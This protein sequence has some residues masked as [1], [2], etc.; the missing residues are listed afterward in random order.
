MPVPTSHS[1]HPPF[2]LDTYL[3]ICSL[4]LCHY[5]CFADGFICTIFLL[6]PYILWFWMHF[7]LFLFVAIL[8]LLLFSLSWPCQVPACFT[9]IFLAF[10][11]EDLHF[12]PSYTYMSLPR[13]FWSLKSWNNILEVP[14]GHISS[15]FFFFWATN[16]LNLLS[17]PFIIAHLYCSAPPWMRMCLTSGG[18]WGADSVCW[19][20]LA[21][22]VF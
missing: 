13:A 10:S 17:I 15:S 14:S 20:G 19:P 1:S 7:Q 5:F 3:C 21:P 18:W 22:L 2:P 4:H 6:S 16:H 11:G 12:L 9:G 8:G